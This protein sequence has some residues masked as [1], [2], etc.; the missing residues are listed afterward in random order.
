MHGRDYV[1]LVATVAAAICAIGGLHVEADAQ[2]ARRTFKAAFYNVKSG[3]GQIGL[4]GFPTP[5]ADTYNCTDPTQPMNAWGTGFF[6]SELTARIGNDPLVVVLGVAEAWRCATP[7]AIQQVLGWAARTSERDGQAVI[8]RYGFAGPEQWLQLDTS[9]NVNPNDLQW[10]VRVPV[11]LDAACRQWMHYIA[12]HWYMVTP[13]EALNYAVGETQARQ[14]VQFMEQLPDGEPRVFMGDLNA[15]EGHDYVCENAPVN[16]AID[17]LRDTGYLDAWRAVQGGLDGSTSAWNRK[18]CGV[19]EGNLYKRIDYAWSRYTAPLS[20]ARFGMVPPGTAA[21]S[22]HAGLMA[23]YPLPDALVG[24]MPP[25]V[26]IRSPTDNLPVTGTI[27]VAV[28][29]SDDIGMSRVELM[30]DGVTQAVDRSSP[31][32]FTWDTRSVANGPHVLRAAATDVTGHRIESLAHTVSV[33]NVPAADDEIVLHAAQA[34]AVHGAWSLVPDSTAASGRRLQNPDAAAPPIATALASPASYVEFT[35]TAKAATPYRLWIRGRASA[36]SPANDSLHLQFD[37]SV[38]AAGAA[39]TRIGTNDSIR[40]NL[41]DCGGCGLLS[42]GWQDNGLPRDVLGPSIYF[43]ATGVQRLRIQPREDGLGIDQ[44]VLSALLHRW[45]SPGALT[46]DATILPATGITPPVNAPPTVSLTAPSSGSTFLA[47]ANITL[48]AQAADADGGIA[49]VE[50]YAGSTRLVSVSSPPFTWTWTGVGAGRYTITARA[51]DTSGAAAPSAGTTIDVL[52]STLPAGWTATDVGTV[53]VRGSTTASGAAFTLRGAGAD[54]WGATDAFHYA[55]RQ[56]AGNGTIVAR[57]AS[58]IG[59][60]AWTKVGVMIRSSTG[61]SAAHAF[62]LI[63]AAKGAA[64]QRRNAEAALT[65][66]TGGGAYAA[67]RWVR[68]TRLGNVIT[69]SVS[70]DGTQWTIVG[71]DLIALPTTALFG[72][73]VTSHDATALATGTLDNVSVTT[74]PAAG[75]TSADIGA[76][77]LA[78]S[79]SESAGTFV[80]RGAGADIWGAADAF[81]YVYRSLAGDGV[82]VARVAAVSGSNPWA[83]V[84]V[85]VRGSTAASAAHAFMLVSAAKGSGFQRRTAAGG[86]SQYTSAGTNGAPRWVKLTRSGSLVTASLSADGAAWTVV[87][88]ATIALPGTALFG[89]AV[90]S[91]DATALATGTFDRVTVAP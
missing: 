75:W 61:A 60:Q 81:H 34:A 65:T 67:P 38:T 28:E 50:F 80:V 57:V 43:A 30:V 13:Q 17:V 55:Y 64:F 25:A 29:A 89:L 41:E 31:Y 14:S 21:P 49:R 88:S 86:T 2:S 79:S 16:V 23:E 1:H 4:T 33:E 15:M 63:S 37:R 56:V 78:G 51:I 85:M 18:N 48:T 54:I 24:T 69:A 8:A 5:F 58:I 83:K 76:T 40:Y 35:F 66:H 39:T 87:G 22:D 52:A 68:L 59:T 53:G 27:S 20:T 26:M 91:H 42:W 74:I 90:T 62:M 9:R 36:D 6:Q 19:P 47:P 72:L 44:I 46:N 70:A 84:G 82:I 3:I 71:S 11:C 10:I 32:A 12:T 7:Q 77:G 45:R 73:A